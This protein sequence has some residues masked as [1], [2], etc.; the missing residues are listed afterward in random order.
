MTEQELLNCLHQ[1]TPWEILHVKNLNKLYN[2][3]EINQAA[4]TPLSETEKALRGDNVNCPAEAFIG[5][6]PCF[7]Q[8]DP[9]SED[10]G[11]E[12]RVF[13]A[14]VEKPLAFHGVRH[15]VHA[16]HQRRAPEHEHRRE[17]G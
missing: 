17:R 2:I 14:Q 12:N 10:D 7:T 3:E 6:Y 9:R 15:A 5:G 4:A 1:Y 16:P 11:P 13:A 8:C